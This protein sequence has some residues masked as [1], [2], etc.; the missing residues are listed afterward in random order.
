MDVG[1]G[2]SLYTRL[3]IVI[4]DDKIR[5]LAPEGFADQVKVIEVDAICKFVVQVVDR[6]RS[7][8]GHAR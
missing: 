1:S 5:Q 2:A 6:R 7:D 8:A 3:C 4:P